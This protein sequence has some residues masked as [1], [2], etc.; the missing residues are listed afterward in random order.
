MPL[1][2]IPCTPSLPTLRSGW[3]LDWH[4]R[5]E[6]SGAPQWTAAPQHP[7]VAP[8]GAGK[9]EGP[10]VWAAWP[11]VS[12]DGGLDERPGPYRLGAY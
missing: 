8:V 6:C 4:S 2:S 10:G 3:V 9:G 5:S 1:V 12:M 7:P 11:L